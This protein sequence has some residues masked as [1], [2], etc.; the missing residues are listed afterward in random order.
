MKSHYPILLLFSIL[1]VWLQA[2][3]SNPNE[4]TVTLEVASETP[5]EA[6]VF[7]CGEEEYHLERAEFEGKTNIKMTCE[8]SGE[9]IF[10]ICVT[11]DGKQF[12]SE[13][14]YVES[15]YRPEIL[16]EGKHFEI[17]EHF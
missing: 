7:Y 9:G 11:T 1:M 13:D 16:F 12:C 5:L 15:G 14:H 3:I 10:S 6:V 8:L 4:L 17:T 2:C